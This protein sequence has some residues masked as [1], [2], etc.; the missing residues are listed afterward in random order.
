MTDQKLTSVN[1]VTEDNANITDYLWRIGDKDRANYH[2]E[3][4]VSATFNESYTGESY[5]TALFN[6]QAYHTPSLCLSMV[7]NAIL[8]VVTNN[9]YSSEITNHPLPRLVQA[10]FN[11]TRHLYDTTLI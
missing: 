10:D 11:L 9:V 4:M 2:N 5:I 3:Y 6:N 8:S 7:S 1:D